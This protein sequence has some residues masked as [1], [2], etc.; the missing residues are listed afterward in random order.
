M[1]RHHR[2][3]TTSSP[4]AQ[5][6]FDQALVWTFAFNHDEAIRSYQQV[7]TLDPNCAMA[8]WGIALCNGPHIN[9]PIVPPER[10]RAAWDALQK[11]IARNGN[12]TPVERALIEALAKRYADPPPEDRKA[13]DEAYAAAMREVWKK[14]PNDADVGA[15]FAEAMM[16]LRPWDLWM[17]D[18]KPQPGT[19][20]IV[21]TLEK[22]ICLQPDHPGAL[23]FH[24]HAIEASPHPEKA[25][26]SADRLRPLVPASGHLVHM[27]T[28]IDVLTGR[29]R[30]A[31]ESNIEAA[32]ADRA[33]RRISPQQDFYRFYMAHNRHML[34][35]ASMMEGR[36]KAAL[37]AVREMIAEVPEDYAR[38][39]AALVDGLMASPYETLMRF[40]QWDEVLREPGPPAHFPIATALWRFTRGVAYAAKGQV[41]E[42]EKERVAFAQ[43]KAAVPKGAMVVLNPAET[44]LQ[45]GK[46]VLDGEIAFRK[47]DIDSAVASL[48][49][50]VRIEDDLKY[51][52]PPEWI[53]PVRHTLGAILASNGRYEEAEKVYREDLKEWPENGWSL[54]GLAQCLRARGA[55]AEADEI[56]KRFRKAWSRADVTIGSS[57][58]CVN[59]QR[60]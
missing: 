8:Y 30:Q 5:K 42:A 24:I 39:N 1:G 20:E 6:Y 14:Y 51:M 10:S 50:A 59:G 27:P 11:A 15:L 25:V 26:A 22:V 54:F 40:G 28:H 35:F 33:Y 60:G 17:K 57:C 43:A 55:T 46:H 32:A 19:D 38:N 47:G 9:N 2:A 18:G 48:R 12:A 56:D 7:A 58:L 23:H 21:A 3:V 29:W 52:E 4:L 31:S 49:E 41:A 16:D 34:G 37:R 13:L 45:I 44:V 53:Q 36:S